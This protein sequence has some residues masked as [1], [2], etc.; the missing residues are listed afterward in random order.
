M[1]RSIEFAA[2]LGL[3]L[4][5]VDDRAR[6]ACGSR[7]Q[8][9]RRA[10]RQLCVVE[11]GDSEPPIGIVKFFAARIERLILR[12]RFTSGRLERQLTRRCAAVREIA[13]LPSGEPAWIAS[14]DV[15]AGRC[16]GSG[17][18]RDVTRVCPRSPRAMPIQ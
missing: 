6:L 5:P 14:A 12:T 2:R 16:R 1:I 9:H 11:C 10:N 8:D 17:T 15:P 18:P 3:A 13:R 4:A 7:A